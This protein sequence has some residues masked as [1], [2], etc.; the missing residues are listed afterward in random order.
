MALY[1]EF[2]ITHMPSESMQVST[3]TSDAQPPNASDQ[4]STNPQAPNDGAASSSVI[5]C[6]NI[7]AN[8]PVHGDHYEY[9]ADADPLTLPD[10]VW[11]R[12]FGDYS[13]RYVVQVQGCQNSPII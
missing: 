5:D 8:A 10:S 11:R 3:L 13:N 6:C 1:P 7:L 9:H 2:S 12:D 4:K